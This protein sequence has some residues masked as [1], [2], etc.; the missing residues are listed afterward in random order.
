MGAFAE[1]ERSLSKERQREGVAFAKARGAYKGRKKML[2][3]EKIEALI[4]RAEDS[5]ETKAQIER[6]LALAGKHSISICE[7]KGNGL[8]VK[9]HRLNN[10]RA[11]D[12][13]CGKSIR[14]LREMFHWR[15]CLKQ[16]NVVFADCV[17]VMQ[18]NPK[19]KEFLYAK[20]FDATWK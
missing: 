17:I 1:F 6:D 3:Q 2:S 12:R 4:K 18:H 11:E 15:L 5:V 10:V 7:Q 13:L 19:I 9:R 14:G 20:P 8:S 16:F